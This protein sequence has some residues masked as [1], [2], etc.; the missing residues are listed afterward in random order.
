MIALLFRNVLRREFSKNRLKNCP[1][2]IATIILRMKLLPPFRLKVTL[3]VI[4][5]ISMHFISIVY[6]EL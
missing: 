4:E 6:F 3:H 5:F 2:T 1:P